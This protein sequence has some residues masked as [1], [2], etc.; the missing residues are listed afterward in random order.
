MLNYLLIA[1]GSAMGGVARWAV[2]NWTHRLAGGTPP[3]VFPI[4]TLVVNATGSFV[5]GVLAALMARPGGSHDGLVRLLFAVGFCGGY[6]T[7]STFSLDTIALLEN[8][9]LSLAAA[10]IA[11]SVGLGLGGV[12]GGMLVGR[13]I[14]SRG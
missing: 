4:G 11:L 1:I 14:F 2:G 12:L 7:F 6:T 9:G 13:L 5:L 8:R 3:A 10:N